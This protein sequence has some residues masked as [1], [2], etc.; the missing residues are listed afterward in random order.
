MPAVSPASLPAPELLSQAVQ[1]EAAIAFWAS[2]S[3]TS[4]EDI[5]KLADGA[6]MRAFY[7]AGLAERDAVQTVKDAIAEA[8]KNGE[9]LADFK[10]RIKDVIDSQG[11]HDNRVETIFRNSLQT[12]YSAGRWQKIQA[13]KKFRP[14]LQ[15]YTAGDERVRPG[16]AVLN[17]LVFPVDHPFWDE[18]Y[19]PNGHKCRCGTR[20]L[21]KR[22]VEA[23]GLTVQEEMPGDMMYVDPK[24]GMEYHVARPGAD[25]GWRNNPGKD[26][27]AGLDLNKYP[28]LN[29]GSHAE[30]RGQKETR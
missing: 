10:E 3:A 14:Y 12:A 28:D 21:S 9:T 4:V 8:L 20:T 6:K 2:R 25:D 7:V 5:K 1:P 24:T 11:W 22:Q 27:L 26:W 15:Y 30:Q 19:T 23:E 16:H 13:N 18:N 29:A 17:E